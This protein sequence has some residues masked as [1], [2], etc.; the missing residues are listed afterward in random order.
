MLL[1][2]GAVRGRHGRE[3]LTIIHGWQ[4]NSNP[5]RSYIL[6]FEKIWKPETRH[7]ISGHKDESG[8][9]LWWFQLAIAASKRLGHQVINI[10]IHMP[11]ISVTR[12]D[13]GSPD[14]TCS[15]TLRKTVPSVIWGLVPSVFW[16]LLQHTNGIRKKGNCNQ[17]VLCSVVLSAS[18]DPSVW[19]MRRR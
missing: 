3:V 13:T 9:N 18:S 17:N 6:P 7:L 2:L 11:V 14:S 10:N 1:I 15:I 12:Y 5:R 8:T 4:V 16:E 19:R